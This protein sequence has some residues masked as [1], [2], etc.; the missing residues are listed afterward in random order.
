MG[1]VPWRSVSCL[2]AAKRL[3]PM[4]YAKDLLS[5]AENSSDPSS[6][7]ASAMPSSSTATYLPRP[8]H[9]PAMRVL[10]AE[11]PG[12]EVLEAGDAA[13][14]VAAV[15]AGRRSSS[16]RGASRPA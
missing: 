7:M 15:T 2:E 10:L 11:V 1:A 16:S 9:R 13:S 4:S 8:P 14:A 3:L 6:I 5:I 12:L